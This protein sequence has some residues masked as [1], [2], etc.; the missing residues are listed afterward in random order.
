MS[1][2]I[3]AFQ[4]YD[5]GLKRVG[6]RLPPL[7][8]PGGGMRFWRE[9]ATIEGVTY[10]VTEGA[11]LTLPDQPLEVASTVQVLTLPLDPTLA[12]SIRAA[13]PIARAIDDL[14][15]AKIR[16]FYS[17]NDEIK[18]LRAGAGAEYSAWVAHAESCRSWGSAQK[19][20]H[21]L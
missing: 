18:L 4:K 10:A 1:L 21:G 3:I 7:F 5:N 15:V 6:L 14:V 9:L 12:A 8:L 16:E 2:I 19:A 17:I 11:G 13:S 20:L